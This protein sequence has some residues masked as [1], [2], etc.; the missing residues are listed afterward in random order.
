M[1]GAFY[2]V[3]LHDS[4]LPI[5]GATG[6]RVSPLRTGTSQLLKVLAALAIAR[7]FF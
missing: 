1:K 7:S 5:L 6:Q 3:D 2:F 4:M